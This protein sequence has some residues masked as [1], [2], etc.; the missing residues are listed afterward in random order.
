[1]ERGEVATLTDEDLCDIASEMDPRGPTATAN[2]LLEFVRRRCGGDRA[3]MAAL[4]AVQIYCIP[5]IR[6]IA[7]GR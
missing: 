1:M 5:D 4:A 3:V 6:D 2:G 7:A